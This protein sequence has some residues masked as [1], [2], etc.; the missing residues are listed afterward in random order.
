MSRTT[1]ETCARDVVFPELNIK[2]PLP[3]NKPV[4]VRVPADAAKTYTF[5]CG[6][7]MYKS[8]LIVTAS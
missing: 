8:S 7:G 6:M 3:L 4:T 1:E 5:Q 2:E